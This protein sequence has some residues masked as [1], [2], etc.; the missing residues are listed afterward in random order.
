MQICGAQVASGH[1]RHMSSL[2][3]PQ[4]ADRSFEKC[5]KCIGFCLFVFVLLCFFPTGWQSLPLKY[6]HS[7]KAVTSC[8]SFTVL[9][10]PSRLGY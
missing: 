3:R 8:T 7:M 4:K 2:S 6:T 9:F 5:F 10:Q 1:Y